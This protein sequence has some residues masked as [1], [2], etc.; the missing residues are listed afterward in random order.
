MFLPLLMKPSRTLE[1]VHRERPD[2]DK[3]IEI[4]AAHDKVTPDRASKQKKPTQ[5]L[6]E[7][8]LNLSD[9]ANKERLNV[10]RQ[11]Q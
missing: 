5:I 2:D 6:G 3:D 1:E 8:I 10:F 4:R 7:I 11:M 9:I